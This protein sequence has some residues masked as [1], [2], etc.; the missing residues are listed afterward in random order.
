MVQQTFSY[1]HSHC[2]HSHNHKCSHTAISAM[3][4]RFRRDP[5]KS[6]EERLSSPETQRLHDRFWWA[7]NET[8][9]SSISPIH[10][11][12]RESTL[13]LKQQQQQQ[14]QQQS[15]ASSDASIS[16]ILRLYRREASGTTFNVSSM[17]NS[18]ESSCSSTRSV[19]SNENETPEELLA[20][21]RRKFRLDDITQSLSRSRTDALVARLSSESAYSNSQ[22]SPRSAIVMPKLLVTNSESQTEVPR[23]QTDTFTEPQTVSD[24]STTTPVMLCNEGQ[25]D[26]QQGISTVSLLAQQKAAIATTA[27]DA[28]PACVAPSQQADITATLPA[29]AP[30]RKRKRQR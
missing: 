2:L 26:V 22:K 25:P 5:P 29:I 9:D 7:R 14:Q 18:V 24:H 11:P 8:L 6:R 4:D 19:S 12:A 30:T 20:R 17:R 21:L 3:I 16:E 13:S 23:M 1:A 28:A 15:I 10:S 27:A